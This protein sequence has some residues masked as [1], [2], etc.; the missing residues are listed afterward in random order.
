MAQLV[1]PLNVSQ[2]VVGLS[3]RGAELRFP[4]SAPR[5]NNQRPWYVQPCVCE[6]A[7]KRSRATYR[8]E[9]GIVSRWLVSS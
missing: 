8:K 4:P 6:W 7:Y 1:V 2:C 3:P 5:L 9:R